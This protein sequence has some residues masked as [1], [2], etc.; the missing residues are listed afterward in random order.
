MSQHTA[1]LAAGTGM[2]VVGM[3]L[4]T[5]AGNVETPVFA[6]DKVGVVLAVLGGIELV[7]TGYLVARRK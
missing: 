2:L 5:T 4:A 3:I 1:S 6:L 7:V